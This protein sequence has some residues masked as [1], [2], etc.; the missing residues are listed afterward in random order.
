MKRRVKYHALDEMFARRVREIRNARGLSMDDLVGR[1]RGEGF[2]LLSSG[3]C[4][5]EHGDRRCS[6]GEAAVIAVALDVPLDA[7]LSDRPF[8]LTVT[9]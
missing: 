4:K 7:L 6:I 5:I 1:L 3:L 9:V 8:T 2:E